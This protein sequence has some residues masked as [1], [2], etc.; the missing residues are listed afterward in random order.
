MICTPI[1]RPVADLSIGTEVAGQCGC[2]IGPDE[3][4]IA[5][6]PSTVNGTRY[7]LI[8]DC[9]RLRPH[10]LCGAAATW[11]EIFLPWL[12]VALTV[13]DPGLRKDLVPRDN[14]PG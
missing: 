13:A 2:G 6:Q 4:H 8:L 9:A 5:R 10:S 7:A 14:Y 12:H 3:A 1:G 11:N